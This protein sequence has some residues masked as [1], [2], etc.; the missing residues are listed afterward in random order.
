[1][2][3]EEPLSFRDLLPQG[4]RAQIGGQ[5]GEAVRAATA[6]AEDAWEDEDSL[7]GG[8][9]SQVGTNVHGEGEFGGRWYSWETHLRKLRG[10]GQNA[11]EKRWGA[12]GIFEIEVTD[13]ESVRRKSLLMQAKKEWGTR[14]RDLVEQC[15]KME[16]TAPGA[17]ILVDFHRRSIGAAI[18]RDVIGAQG[19]RRSLDDSAYYDLGALL[20]SHFL[21]CR[22]GALN[23]YYD[24]S[25]QILVQG[26]PEGLVSTRYAVSHRARTVISS[27]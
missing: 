27:W 9:I 17:G 5:F 3:P 7:T 22:V 13:G 19:R 25:R 15:E 24:A 6:T 12:D 10:R 23:T 1:M 4:L 14:D 20:Q 21:E 11:I 26:A 2:Q 8:L 16:Q 18:G